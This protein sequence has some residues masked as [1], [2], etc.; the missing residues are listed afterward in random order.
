[1]RAMR[2]HTGPAGPLNQMKSLVCPQRVAV[3]IVLCE[4]WA[5]LRAVAK[6]TAHIGAK[7]SK[8][9][10]SAVYIYED[11][12]AVLQLLLRTLF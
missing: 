9:K 4:V 3:W 12:R 2:L 11:M 8:G 6:Q 1:M 7:V 5:L 10:V